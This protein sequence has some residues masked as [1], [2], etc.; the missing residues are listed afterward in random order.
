MLTIFMEK[1]DD[2]TFNTMLSVLQSGMWL[3]NDLETYLRPLDMSQARLS[4]L[5]AITESSD[6]IISPKDIARITGKSRPAI[7]RT[8]DSLS[9]RGLLSINRDFED[10]RR[11]KLTLTVKGQELLN[12]LI[13][14]YNQQILAM[15]SRFTEEE[16][17]LLGKLLGKINFL[18]KKENSQGYIMNYTSLFNSIKEKSHRGSSADI[19][20]IMSTLNKAD[21]PTTR[22]VDFYLGS[23]TNRMGL[24]RLEYY[25]FSGT[26]RQRNYAALF[27]A[28]KNEWT[29]INRAVKKGCIDKI[30]AYSR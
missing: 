9:E 21:L 26:Q 11:K 16:K 14:T 1:L 19:D 10:G 5:L 4:I 18:H 12:T 7:T 15:C 29:I 24:K 3:L 25:L 28:R 6:G 2:L 20:S 30:Q 13:P 8:I 27:F 23:V 22:A 17:L